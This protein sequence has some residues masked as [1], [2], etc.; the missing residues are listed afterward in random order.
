MLVPRRVPGAVAQEDAD[1]IVHPVGRCLTHGL[2]QPTEHGIQR[3]CPLRRAREDCLAH[4]T[5]G[6]G[7]G[8]SRRGA[9]I[10]LEDHELPV[11]PSDEVE[12]DHGRG[13]LANEPLHLRL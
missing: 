6:N 12:A 11:L 10:V 13:L 3:E 9:R 5:R 4:T 8:H 2:G 1:G 7:I